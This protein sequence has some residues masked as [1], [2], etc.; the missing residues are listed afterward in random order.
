MYAT[1]K[2]DIKEIILLAVNE[3]PLQLVAQAGGVCAE[4][5]LL[6]TLQIAYPIRRVQI[7]VH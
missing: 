1:R 3:Q 2:T 5:Q 4:Q 6:A 7:D